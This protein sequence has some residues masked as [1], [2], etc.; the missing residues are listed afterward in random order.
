MTP[1]KIDQGVKSL[2]ATKL[3][4]TGEQRTVVGPLVEYLLFCPTQQ[5]V[6]LISL[7]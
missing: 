4:D 7:S 6:D 3:N 5:M 1:S 2:I